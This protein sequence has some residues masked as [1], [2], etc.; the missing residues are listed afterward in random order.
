MLRRSMAKGSIGASAT[1]GEDG[2]TIDDEI[3]STNEP[4]T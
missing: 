1:P 3:T 4:T 2:N